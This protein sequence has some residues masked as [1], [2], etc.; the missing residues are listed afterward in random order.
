M[1][2]SVIIATFNRRFLLAR[3]LP[4][5]LQQDFDPQQYEVIVVVDGSID[6]TTEFLNTL[7][8]RG[9]LRIVEQ[10]NQGQAAAI[11][12]GLRESLGELVLFLD[13]D[14]LCGP[15]LVAEHV[16]VPRSGTAC[17]AFGPVLVSPEGRDPLALDW[18]R[19]YCDDFFSKR[20]H[21]APQKGWYGCMASANSSLPREVALSVGGLDDTFSRG[22]DVEFGFRLQKA[23]YTFVYQPSAITHQI[24]NKTRHDVIEDASG[25]GAAEVRLSRKFPELRMASRLA[26]LSSRP[27]W[28][29][30]AARIS[31]TSPVPMVAIF[32]PFTWTCDKLRSVPLFRRFALRLL[33]TQ[34]NVA[35]WRSA[36]R[37]AG[38]WKA[39]Q[40]EYGARLPILMYHS[41]G[42]LRAGSD[43]FLNIPIEMFESQLR[44]LRRKGF[45]PIHV[46]DWIAYQ[47]GVTRLPSKPIVLTFDDAYRDTAEFGF[48]LL[49]K[50][51]FKG[52]LFVVTNHIGGTNEWDLP[53]GVSEQPLMTA[54]EICYWAANGIEVGS[55][56]QSHPDLRRETE[57]QILEEMTMSRERL[58]SVLGAPVNVFAYP[59][60][61]FD[62]RA[63]DA[64]RTV[65]D[66][67]L[68]CDRGINVLSTDP[69]QLRRATIVPAYRPGQMFWSTKFGY[70]LLLNL[71]IHAGLRL[72]PILQYLRLKREDFPASN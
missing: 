65:Y 29:R 8:H 49:K 23:G 51:G 28:K 53:L 59:Y 68:T 60:G 36:V 10:A 17:M 12:T 47:R 31:A 16:K 39:L 26:L 25:E 2:I 50:Y 71:R 38:S 61:Y 52:T 37:E 7:P 6:G 32:T 3:T 34:Q 67:A 62:E 5:L 66:A 54:E 55:H 30:I 57:E 9:N 43:P 22:N 21:E 44:W 19:T 64:A 11:N 18:A 4:S 63:S 14:I 48:P 46:A 72:R 35:A 33:Q 40:Q 13:D 45:T 58:E 27:W 24:Y 41:V 42:P 20:V 69:M 56:S 70:N 1:K 15:D